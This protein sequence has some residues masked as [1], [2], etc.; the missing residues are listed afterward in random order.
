MSYGGPDAPTGGSSHG[1]PDS[2][3][4]P[5]GS[6]HRPANPLASEPGALLVAI[7]AIAV[8]V[9][10][11]LR[12]WGLSAWNMFEVWDLVLAALAVAALVLVAGRLGLA[13]P[14][15]DRWLW[16]CSAAI[17]VIVIENLINKP[18]NIQILNALSQGLGGPHAPMGPGP[19]IALAGGLV[20]LLGSALASGVIPT[21]S[22]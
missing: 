4:A 6:Q 1:G 22:H 5:G 19:W 8:F 21:K 17:L 14:A 11:F 10:L 13:R 2:P 20:M 9:S 7:G 3:D 12:W 15:P 18:P 16:A